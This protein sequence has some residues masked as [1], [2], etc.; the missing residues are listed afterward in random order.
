[1]GNP[2]AENSEVLEAEVVWFPNADDVLDMALSC[3]DC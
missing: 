3:L 2:P 1:V